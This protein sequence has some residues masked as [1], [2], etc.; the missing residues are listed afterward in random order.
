M[1]Y[2]CLALLGTLCLL[3]DSSHPAPA[4]P[5]VVQAGQTH[6][7]QADLVLNGDDVLEIRGTPEEPCVLVGNRHRIRSGPNWTGV[8]KITHCTIRD[9]GGLPRRTPDGLVSGPG[10][11][12]IELKVA[13]KG[14]VVIERCTFDACS[15]IH[16]QTD[17]ASS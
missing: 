8:L 12:A 15:A 6:T 10:P 13:G 4:A 14:Q 1:K 17:G 11:D 5:V 9:V 16:L 7:L 2:A 3:I